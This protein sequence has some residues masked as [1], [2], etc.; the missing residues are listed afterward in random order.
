MPEFE[1][2]E[3]YATPQG[4]RQRIPPIAPHSLPVSEYVP[5]NRS[6]QHR[7]PRRER[8][9]KELPDIAFEPVDVDQMERDYRAA[10]RAE[11]KLLGWWPRWLSLRALKELLTRWQNRR[12]RAKA[13]R[14]LDA[15][16]RKNQQA[17]AKQQAG[18]PTKSP[19]KPGERS[20]KPG[21]QSS[22][23]RREDGRRDGNRNRNSNK[24]RNRDRNR[25]PNRDQN[26]DADRDGGRDQNR[27]AP[28]DQNRKSG[29]DGSRDQGRDQNRPAERPRPAAAAPAT[30]RPAAAPATDR[31]ADSA[32]PV[33]H[34]STEPATNDIQ[35]TGGDANG[36]P[37]RKRRRNRGRGADNRG[38]DASGNTPRGPGPD[39][40]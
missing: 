22:G 40:E 29:G 35:S 33:A 30:D 38:P 18:G 23:P 3:K 9:R 21:S 16:T 28:R 4:D 37:R 10:M 31:P 11:F 6:R 17:A 32:V 26:R 1:N 7:P 8:R 25:D 27:D 14:L 13:Q 15:I 2:I 24:D 34:S 36:Q 39:E 5:G 12:K 20:A 19:G